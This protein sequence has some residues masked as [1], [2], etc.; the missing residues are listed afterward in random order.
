MRKH[1][2]GFGDFLGKVMGVEVQCEET[3]QRQF[4]IE[5]DDGDKEHLFPS[6]LQPIL[7]L[8]DDD[9]DDDDDDYCPN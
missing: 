5:Y 4:L 3:G 2:D 6:E 8:D 1:F 7:T 9:D